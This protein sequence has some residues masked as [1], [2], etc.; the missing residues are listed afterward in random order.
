MLNP[1]AIKTLATTLCQHKS[2][3]NSSGEE[4]FAHF[5]QN[6]LSQWDYFKV[7]PDRL[8]SLRTLNDP[9][10]RYSLFALVKSNSNRVK[11]KNNKTIILTGHY[12][13]VSTENYGNLEPLAC[14]PEELLEALI[15]ELKQSGNSPQALQDFESGEFFLV[16]A[17]LI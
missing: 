7:H 17:S 15:K 4:E 9:Y 12:D 8:W 11:G 14:E 6:I 16:A 1:K 3:T 13:T 5:L 10:E 2:V